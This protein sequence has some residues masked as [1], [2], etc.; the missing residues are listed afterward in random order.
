[1]EVREEDNEKDHEEDYEVLREAESLGHSRAMFMRRSR[2]LAQ[3]S[4]PC[5]GPNQLRAEDKVVSMWSMW[6]R[7]Y[8]GN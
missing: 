7:H 2:I 6:K 5:L 8:V 4:I 3:G 1:M